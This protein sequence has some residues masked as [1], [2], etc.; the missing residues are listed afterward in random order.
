MSTSSLHRRRIVRREESFD[1]PVASLATRLRAVERSQVLSL[2]EELEQ[3]SLRAWQEGYDA[4]TAEF[5]TG[6]EANRSAQLRRLAEALC[7]AA[8]RVGETRRESVAVGEV[9][10]VETACLLAEAILERELSHSRAALEAATRALRLVPEGEDLVVKVNPA[11]ELMVE[12]IQDLV[13]DAV[14]KVVSDPAVEVG[15]CVVAAGACRID[16]QIG[17]ALQRARRVLEE[18]NLTSPSAAEAGER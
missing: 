3:A 15:G 10:V 18:L 2:K 4:A 8:E 6:Q 13:P 11:D 1:A 9:E 17:P 5:A 16:A 7:N 14:I 12:D